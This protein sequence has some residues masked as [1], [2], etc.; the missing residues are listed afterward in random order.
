MIREDD[1]LYANLPLF[2]RRIK[3]AK[4]FL[5]LA[6]EKCENPGVSISGGK[7]S[8]CLLDM[9][10]EQRPDAKIYFFD[11]GAEFPETYEM[12]EKF[13][14]RYEKDVN[15]IDPPYSMLELIAIAEE[16]GSTKNMFKEQ[17]IEEPSKF[18]A[19]EDNIDMFFVGL[20]KEESRGRRMGLSQ[21]KESYRYDKRL[22]YSLAYPI[23]NLKADDVF[24]YIASRNLPLHPYYDDEMDMTDRNMK[25]VGSWAGDTSIASGRWY[26]LKMTHPDIYIKLKEIDGRTGEYS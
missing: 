24:A 3:Q 5:A 19:K 11:S 1:L 2:K 12:M 9:V 18:A 6:L 14:K 26:W 21:M 8:T 10:M 25:R 7:D 23:M 20:R 4:G 13:E 15:I 17:L 22:K 16:H